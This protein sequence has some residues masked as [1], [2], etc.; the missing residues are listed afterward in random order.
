MCFRVVE[1]EYSYES[2]H[3]GEYSNILDLLIPLKPGYISSSSW[4]CF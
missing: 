1:I 4:E 3:R 2:Y